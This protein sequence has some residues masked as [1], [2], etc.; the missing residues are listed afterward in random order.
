MFHDAI[1]RN[2]FIRTWRESFFPLFV[3][4]PSSHDSSTAKSK[5][6]RISSV[7]RSDHFLVF[8]GWFRGYKLRKFSFGVFGRVC[9]TSIVE[10][11][12]TFVLYLE[13]V[14]R[15]LSQV[16]VQ[17]DKSWTRKLLL[18]PVYFVKFWFNSMISV[19]MIVTFTHNTNLV[20]FA[21]FQITT[22]DYNKH[23]AFKKNSKE[24]P[25]IHAYKLRRI[26]P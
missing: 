21:S 23:V 5:L 25:L 24:A 1:A 2:T 26:T 12:N 17:Q 3:S 7:S 4:K 22:T 19:R 16:N 15:F 10:L 11:F 18:D 9:K 8:R 20:Y 13:E 6:Q 14:T